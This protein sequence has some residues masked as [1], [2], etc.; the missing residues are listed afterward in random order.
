MLRLALNDQDVTAPAAILSPEKALAQR[1]TQA[2]R[3]LRGLK[4]TYPEADCELNFTNALELLI[5]T[6]L[7]AQCT[8][9]R[10]NQVTSTLFHKY[11]TANDFAE[12]DQS[13][14]EEELKPTGFFRQKAFSV[15]TT[16]QMLRD[17]YR[18]EVPK[19]L[20]ELVKLA[21]VARKTANVVL[22]TAY[23]I[24]SGVVVDTHVK[25]LAF[26]W[27]LTD[28]EDPEK[29]ERDLMA[30]IPKKDWVF[31]GHATIWHGRR[32]CYARKPDCLT[33]PMLSFCPQRGLGQRTTPVRKPRS[34]ARPA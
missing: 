12:S 10:V 19:K 13:V 27:G 33:C 29:V 4:E 2:R 15:R 23:G 34:K 8:D 9:V 18:S 16:C 28:E 20:S 25:R 6:I 32:Q 11:R 14:L 30:L 17:N 31:F 21:G 22:G 3:V 7:S 1:K 5:A 24:A 26:R